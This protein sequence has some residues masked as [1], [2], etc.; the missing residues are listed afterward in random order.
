[1]N[2]QEHVPFEELARKH[3]LA[4]PPAE[5]RL[6]AKLVEIQ[7]RRMAARKKV[8]ATLDNKYLP[9]NDCWEVVK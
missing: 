6:A 5:L 2:M 4:T 9:I 1:M 8:R 3:I 7:E